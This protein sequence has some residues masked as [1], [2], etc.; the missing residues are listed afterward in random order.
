VSTGA[1]FAPLP[2]RHPAFP[3]AA[4]RQRGTVRA[5]FFC[6]SGESAA[7]LMPLTVVMRGLV[8]RLS[9]SLSP[10]FRRVSK[11]T[12]A[13]TARHARTC[14]AHPRHASAPLPDVDDRNKSGHDD[15]GG[16][17]RRFFA[18]PIGQPDSLG[19][20]PA[21]TTRT[22]H[23]DRFH[24]LTTSVLTPTLRTFANGETASLRALHGRSNP[25]RQARSLDRFVASLLAMTATA[26]DEAS[27]TGH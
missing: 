26:K 22:I 11:S 15:R 14:S 20:R 7:G 16:S 4:L 21:M 1:E 2:A 5:K 25:E 27:E 17:S 3:A 12:P 8:P 23:R 19:T 18:T 13:P 9:G 24:N 6:A 10:R